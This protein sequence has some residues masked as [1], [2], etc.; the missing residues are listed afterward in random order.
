MPQELKQQNGRWVVVGA[1]RSSDKVPTTRAKPAA[2]R[3]APKPAARPRPRPRPAPKTGI[4]LLLNHLQFEA[5]RWGG[6]AAGKRQPPTPANRLRQ[7]AFN[8]VDRLGVARSAAVGVVG[9]ADNVARLGY[10]AYQRFV[11][12]RPKADPNRGAVGAAINRA[13]E[14][15]FRALGFKP[16]SEMNLDE[17]AGD[18]IRRDLVGNLA[19]APITPGF[20]AARATTTLGRV[21]RGGMA[22]GTNE[23]MST[24]VSDNT[25]GNV[26]NLAEAVTGRAVPG[27]VNVGQDDMVDAAIKSVVPNAIPGAA[28]GVGA[29]LAGAFVHSRRSI[30]SHRMVAA[31]KRQRAKQE[32]MGLLDKDDAGGHQFNPEAQQ[33]QPP[34]TPAGARSF[35]DANAEMEARLGSEPASAPAAPA[36]PAPAMAPEIENATTENFGKAQPG[37]L[38]EADPELDPWEVDYDPELPE[39]TALGAALEELS[40]EELNV[41]L[42]GAGLPVVDRVN[43]TMGARAAVDPPPAVDMGMVMAPAGQLADDYLESITRRLGAREDWQ[44][45]PL[46]D[47]TTNPGLWERAQAIAGVDEPEQLTKTDMLDTLGSFAAEGQVPIVNRLMGGQMMPTSEIKADPAR[48]QYKQGVNAAGEQIGNSLAGVERWD[49]DAEGVV[50]VWRD[51]DDGQVY[52]VNGHNRLARAQQLGV[53]SLRVEMLDAATAPDARLQGAIA[54]ISDGKGTVFDA[55]KLAREYGVTDV[56]QLKA[57][58]K[59]G[60]SGLWK[61]G[62]ALAR[63][64]EDV[65]LAAVNEQIP[66]RR[67]VIIGDFGAD[68]E[69]MRAAYRYLVQQGP[70]NVREATLREMLEMAG[71]SPAAS[72]SGGRQTVLGEGTEWGVTW[73]TGLLAKADLAATVKA[74]LRKE[75]KLFGTVGRQAGEIERVGQ[76]NAGAAQEISDAAGRAEAIYDQLKYQPGPIGDLLNEGTQR[77]V[78]GESPARVAQQIKQRLAAAIE[79]VMG[80]APRQAEDV[81]QEDMLAGLTPTADAPPARVDLTAGER[82][83]AEEQLLREAIANGEVRPPD[84]PIPQLPDPPRARLDQLDPDEPI[85]AGSKAEQAL[86]DEARLAQEHA[87]IDTALA[88]DAEQ[89]LRDGEGYE[90]LTF[91][92]KARHGMTA[93]L[94]EAPG[95]TP[96]LTTRAGKELLAKAIN[97][98]ETLDDVKRR[99]KAF[100]ARSHDPKVPQSERDA[101]LERAAEMESVIPKWEKLAAD[102][103]AAAGLGD[104]DLIPAPKRPKPIRLARR[105]SDASAE[106]SVGGAGGKRV[107]EQER[108]RRVAE[109]GLIVKQ[110]AG[111]E[112]ST[113][114][115]DTYIEIVKPA[116]W[117]GDGKSKDRQLGKYDPVEDLLIVNGVAEGDLNLLHEV[118]YHE[119]WHRIQ[120]FTLSPKEAKILNTAFARIKTAIAAGHVDQKF[121]YS[122]TQAVAFQR[123]AAARK[124][125]EDPIT[126][127]AGG[128]RGTAID[129][130]AARMAPFFDRIL[131]FIERV[132]NLVKSGGFDSTRAIFERARRGALAPD[133]HW[134]TSGSGFDE[135]TRRGGWREQAWDG[136][137]IRA[138][139]RRNERQIA[140]NNEAIET[141][142]RKAQQEGC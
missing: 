4:A 76:V 50:Q 133:E 103:R 96:D 63:L 89:A 139:M 57:M 93:G 61:E 54:N 113:R 88:W 32:A 22:F 14:G 109:L 68:E 6:L 122:E 110:V 67:A 8:S 36:A 83:A 105:Q 20:G 21:V 9:A 17:L 75:K 137:P 126:A 23:A 134:D 5:K 104:E 72:S 30:R 37:D 82:A 60:A 142:T 35:A 95:E 45:R 127:I 24:A 56:A 117:G 55:A 129:K 1:E 12:K 48:F 77:V 121:A 47:P 141:I 140:T 15:G 101:A 85:T 49:P 42:Q 138:A 86:A 78:N 39:S 65:F 120:Y 136:T 102:A 115:N 87:E 90:A 108:Q 11:E 27:A 118:A 10:S 73:N 91:E 44:L 112:V 33:P 28:L 18:Q 80:A 29:G 13:T 128:L 79:E 64:P 43:Q 25:G 124:R 119:A 40:D 2:Q 97:A 69:T 59:P 34:A 100:Q 131:D 106:T 38:P 53:P 7:A 84:Q 16:P 26:A 41:I 74:M 81:V 52:V 132:Y 135:M 58:G 114:F 51:P 123:Y 111:P 99:S 92:E 125:G 107:S 66:V 46:F 70:D 98:Q 31:E 94:E 62:I 3:G 116:A 130:A 71:S 19:V